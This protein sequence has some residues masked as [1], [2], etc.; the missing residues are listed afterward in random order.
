MRQR[1]NSGRALGRG[2]AFGRGKCSNASLSQLEL[3][4]SLTDVR[5]EVYLLEAERLRVSR[6]LVRL[7]RQSDPRRLEHLS[8]R[9]CFVEA[10]LEELEAKTAG[11]WARIEQGA[12][13][14]ASLP[15]MPDCR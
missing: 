1:R 7:D 9:Q 11:L 15:V 6:Q 10:R 5:A 3:E 2:E 12:G 14:D 4:N 13:G 8:Q